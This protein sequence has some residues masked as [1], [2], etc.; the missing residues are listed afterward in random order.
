M[1]DNLKLLLIATVGI[2]E[3]IG[4]LIGIKYICLIYGG[5]ERMLQI[6]LLALVT[7]IITSY[8]KE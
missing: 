8:V 6:M 5:D 2:V 3:V 1:G 4:L 7:I